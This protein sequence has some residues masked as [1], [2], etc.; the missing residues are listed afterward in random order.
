MS[1]TTVLIVDDEPLARR[2]LARMLT[3]LKNFHLV[4]EASDSVSAFDQIRLTDPDILLLDIQLPGASGF[5]LLDRLGESAPVVVFVTAF[6][7]YA[8]RAFDASA[9]DYV[10]KPVDAGRL[11][12]AM[13][14]ARSLAKARRDDAR[15]AE[16]TETVAAL[17]AAL[18]E[19]ERSLTDFWVKTKGGH[20]RVPLNLILSIQAERD[21]VRVFA[22][23]ESYL[24]H[25]SLASIDQRL[26]PREFLRIHRSAIV[27][28][29]R[30]VRLRTA[31]FGALVAV[32]EDGCEIRVGRTYAK[33]VREL[34]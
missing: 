23:G 4:G 29:D 16:L 19:S 12:A 28:L 20:V 7:H 30:I 8:L 1:D 15:V 22:N 27:R 31:P 11:A 2:R 10:T 18:R 21:Y 26:D 5:D 9:A 13:D 3:P 17:R 32:L 14:R 6:D 34:L 33:K 25:E 24:L